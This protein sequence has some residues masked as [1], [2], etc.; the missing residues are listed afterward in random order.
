MCCWAIFSQYTPSDPIATELDST[1]PLRP[2]AQAHRRPGKASWSPGEGQAG[3]AL[4]RPSMGQFNWLSLGWKQQWW[5]LCVH[6]WWYFIIWQKTGAGLHAPWSRTKSAAI[7]PPALL[8]P[9]GKV[10]FLGPCR[11]PPRLT[12]LTLSTM[13]GRGGPCPTVTSEK[14]AGPCSHPALC[15]RLSWITLAS[16]TVPRT[17][18]R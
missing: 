4:S 2:T 16:R 7:S 13:W 1:A 3:P 6:T 15:H 12:A 5:D 18:W 8:D 11:L 9:P 10:I 17:S 14:D